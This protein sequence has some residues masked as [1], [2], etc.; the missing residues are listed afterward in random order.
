MSKNQIIKFICKNKNK[1]INK[2]IDLYNNE[3]IK[4][5]LLS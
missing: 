1:Y 3:F 2:Y 5:L 4:T